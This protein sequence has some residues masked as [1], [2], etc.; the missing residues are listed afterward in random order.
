M[1]MDLL[2][3]KG[4]PNDVSLR[5]ANAISNGELLREIENLILAGGRRKE[6]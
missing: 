3:L 5:A 6:S 1:E 2:M 4:G